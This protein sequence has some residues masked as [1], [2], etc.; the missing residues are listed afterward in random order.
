MKPSRLAFELLLAG[1]IVVAGRGTQR[2]NALDP[3]TSPPPIEIPL[4]RSPLAAAPSLPPVEPTALVAP[5]ALGQTIDD[6]L[7]S[8][9]ELRARK[10]ELEKQ[11]QTLIKALRDKLKEQRERLNK[12]GIEPEDTP[13]K[14]DGKK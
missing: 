1:L 3:E 10:A 7:N 9:A 4:P 5:T 13:A 6:L 11:E 8:L 14:P 2:A 12:V